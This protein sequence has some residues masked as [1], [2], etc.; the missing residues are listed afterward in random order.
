[1][2]DQDLF[3][4]EEAEEERPSEEL[5]DELPDEVPEADAAEQARPLKDAGA[6]RTDRVGDKPEADALEQDRI[7]GSE[8]DDD[9][10]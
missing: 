5:P 3:P 8:D 7:E 2:S 6:S 10:R 1:M 9:P 4:E